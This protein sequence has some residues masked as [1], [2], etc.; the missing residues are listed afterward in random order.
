MLG[1]DD[2]ANAVLGVAGKVIDRVWPDPAQAADAK[3]KLLQLAQ[4]GTLKQLMADTDLAKAQDAINQAE[5]GNTS[6]FVAGWRPFIGWCCGLVL[7]FNYIAAPLVSWGAMLLGAK[8]SIP[9]LGFDQIQPILYGMLGLGA[10]RT[11][12][13]VNGIKAGQ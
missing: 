7:G 9:T 6:T 10:M 11:V 1:V 12:E 4:D 3:F 13:K 5:A 2:I 8:V